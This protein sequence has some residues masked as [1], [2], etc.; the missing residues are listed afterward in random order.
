MP[1]SWSME[2]EALMANI[3]LRLHEVRD[4]VTERSFWDAF[5]QRFNDETDGVHRSKSRVL[6]HWKKIELECLRY[7]AIYKELLRTTEDPDRLCTANRMYFE[8]YGKGIN[9][10]HVWFVLRNHYAWEAHQP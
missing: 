7:N 4:P 9:Y 8:R 2:E 1:T 3:W 6:S 10:Q 5:A